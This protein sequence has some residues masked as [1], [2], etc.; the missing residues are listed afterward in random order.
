MLLHP[1]RKR[2]DPKVTKKEL[3]DF[4]Q[5]IK[6]LWQAFLCYFTIYKLRWMQRPRPTEV[7]QPVPTA[8]IRK[9]SILDRFLAWVA[10][11]TRGGRLRPFEAPPVRETKAT[12]IPVIKQETEA[13]EEIPRDFLLLWIPALIFYGFG[14]VMTSQL[15]FA[16]GAT[17]ANPLARLL[18]GL[19]SGIWIFALVKTIIITSLLF[20]SYFKFG[21]YGW[22]IPVVLTIVGGYLVGN[23]LVAFLRVR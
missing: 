20:L 12:A 17:E 18:V 1:K 15:A 9:R 21:K 4:R 19:P 23:N 10:S 2:H 5:D 16:V 13:V 22:V 7:K 6:S 3:A 8:E 14:D 11:H